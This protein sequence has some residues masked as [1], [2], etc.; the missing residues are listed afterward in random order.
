MAWTWVKWPLIGQYWA[1]QDQTNLR[2]LFWQRLHLQVLTFTVA[3]AVAIPSAPLLLGLLNTDKTI[4]PTIWLV[5]LAV[6]AL[7]EMHVASWNQL[8][9]TTN[10][11]PFVRAM[12]ASSIGSLILA[13]VLVHVTTLGPGALI[14]APLIAGSLL[15]YWY[16]P[17]HGARVLQ[18]TWWRFIFSRPS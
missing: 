9:A 10:H 18:Q 17:G 1:Q 13:F 8:I 11:F 2:C 16:W 6:N 4:L 7:F 3:V 14:L 12:I 5:V 15:N